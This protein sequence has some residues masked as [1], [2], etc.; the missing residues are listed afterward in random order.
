MF[1][2]EV[3]DWGSYSGSL[4]LAALIGSVRTQSAE[5]AMTGVR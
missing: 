5:C 4:R 2:K 3:R 1:Y